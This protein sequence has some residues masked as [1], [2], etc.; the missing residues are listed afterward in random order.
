MLFFYGKS[1]LFLDCMRTLFII[2]ITFMRNVVRINLGWDTDVDLI[3]GVCHLFN[4]LLFSLANQ[5]CALA[6]IDW[7]AAVA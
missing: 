3:I 7:L 5:G 1:G 6:S 4:H 2:C